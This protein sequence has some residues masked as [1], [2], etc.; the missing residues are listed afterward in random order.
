MGNF[1]PQAQ[2]YQT[3]HGKRLIG[4]YLSR[5][6]SS[7]KQYYRR[8]PVMSALMQLSE[9]KPLERWQL[10]A[11]AKNAGEFL[12][13]SRLG[14]V[15]WRNEVI[16]PD[17]RAFAIDVLRLTKVMEADGYELYAPR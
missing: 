11:A 1:G 5:V 3:F 9:G 7:S 6:D 16:T 12:Q 15:V 4:G 2:Y 17:L 13:R 10:E 14:Y 8:L